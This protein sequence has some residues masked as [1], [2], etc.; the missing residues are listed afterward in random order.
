MIR[1]TDLDDNENPL[2]KEELERLVQS[3]VYEPHLA[4][5][6]V[7]NI[8]AAEQVV[9]T[10]DGEPA[11][12]EPVA[13]Q[14]VEVKEGEEEADEEEIDLEALDA[15]AAG[16]AGGSGSELPE[17][18]KSGQEG[19]V[20]SESH[21]PDVEGNIEFDEQY[22]DQ[23]LLPFAP[24]DDVIPPLIA[25]DNAAILG[26]SQY[27]EQFCFDFNDIKQEHGF[28]SNDFNIVDAL[29]GWGNSGHVHNIFNSAFMSTRNVHESVSSE[30]V[31][32]SNLHLSEGALDAVKG[33]DA[34]EGS[35]IW[36]DVQLAPGQVIT[37]DFFFATNDPRDYDDNDFAFFSISGESGE[38]IYSFADTFST[39]YGSNVYVDQTWW[40]RNTGWQSDSFKVPYTW[41]AGV[42]RIGF[43]V[44]DVGSPNQTYSDSSMLLIDDVCGML[45][46][47]MAFGNVI[48]DPNNY[49]DS[50]DPLSAIDTPENGTK[51]T[52]IAFEYGSGAQDFIEYNGLGMLGATVVDGYIVIP[53]PDTGEWIDI[54]TPHNN[55]LLIN[56]DGEYRYFNDSSE[57]MR[58]FRFQEESNEEIF[59]YRLEDDA[60]RFDN[61][62]LVITTVNADLYECV[63]ENNRSCLNLVLAIDVSGSMDDRL[64]VAKQAAVDLIN[65]YVFLGYILNITV[66]PFSGKN[67][68]GNAY[69]GA[70]VYK[71][72]SADNAKDYIHHLYE[73]YSSL[74]TSTEYD[75]LLNIMQRDVL[76]PDCD[77]CPSKVYILTD[78]DDPSHGQGAG[79]AVEDWQAFV[80][81]NGIDV[82]VVLIDPRSVID[83]TSNTALMG[84][85]GDVPDVIGNVGDIKGL[86]DNVMVPMVM[87]Y[88]AGASLLD[89][90]NTSVGGPYEVVKITVTFA[91][92]DVNPIFFDH[93]LESYTTL[94]A[95]IS[96][97]GGYYTV[98]ADVPVVGMLDMLSPLGGL[99]SVERDGTYSYRGPYSNFE[100]T[101]S[102]HF[103]FTYRDNVLNLQAEA[104]LTVDIKDT[105]P[106]AYNNARHI[107]IEREVTASDHFNSSSNWSKDGHYHILSYGGSNRLY[108]STHDQGSG[109][110]S[111][112]S[113]NSLAT[114]LGLSSNS[115]DDV[116][117]YDAVEGSAVK[118]TVYLDPG[119]I[120]SFD[121]FFATNAHDNKHDNDFGFMSLSGY[122]HKMVYDFVDTFDTPYTS[123]VNIDGMWWDENSGWRSGEFI[124]PLNWVSGN[125]VLGFGVM[126]VGS[127]Y[128]GSGDASMILVDNFSV[129]SGPTHSKGNVIS[130]P[131]SDFKSSDPLWAVDEVRADGG[132]VSWISFQVDGSANS[133]INSHNLDALVNAYGS[134]NTVYVP[135]D[136]DGVGFETYHGGW[137]SIDQWGNY[138]YAAPYKPGVSSETFQYTLSEQDG[139]DSDSASLT[140]YFT[141]EEPL[142]AH[143]YGSGDYDSKQYKFDM[144]SDPSE[145]TFIAGL[146][147]DDVLTFRDVSDVH[148]PIGGLSQPDFEDVVK[149]WAQEGSNVA[150][151]LQNN[152]VLV[153]QDIGNVP[154]SGTTSDLQ[155]YLEN[156]MNVELNV[157]GFV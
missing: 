77:N 128:N 18:I 1:N 61:A 138:D 129:I 104:V 39:S 65:Q 17:N 96:V 34:V 58:E 140:F 125:Y 108:L 133:Y 24:D 29:D 42:Y 51:V 142:Y 99:L 113:E 28:G 132:M 31:I 150:I 43:G 6:G 13:E 38:I 98:M 72:S 155:S 15:S 36:Y 3:S 40:D 81:A 145:K 62:L 123:N 147:Q 83:S 119:Q 57:K 27:S 135:V 141:T 60:G 45:P 4:E 117:G 53:V 94:G 156:T 139:N 130:D 101:V 52:E 134:G 41:D 33:F 89:N 122:G 37:F 84:N 56:S 76:G 7:F 50:L 88:I 131:N 73:G 26:R 154:G 157:S 59:R 79:N 12:G 127:P 91:E 92:S 90:V 97:V 100:D 149:G 35:A 112:I 70:L 67:L 148:D 143:E 25:F 21:E 75:D 80:D 137:I 2:S 74:G 110:N 20:T 47:S 105:E 115:L 11:D 107:S 109:H 126:D 66:M 118:Q 121:Y 116:K 32:S 106:T 23:Q 63:T 44:V 10:E 146:N 144:D 114:F 16:G 19:T 153:L 78:G 14:Q 68:E 102:D 30:S 49:I 87:P 93:L 85:A 151:Q 71:A 55:H 124:V 86:L 46:P 111:I 9:N 48:H 103:T 95:S 69:D 22:K 64:D 136:V 152:N 5:T 82:M 54:L 120:I 8:A